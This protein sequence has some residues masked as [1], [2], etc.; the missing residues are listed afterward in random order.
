VPKELDEGEGID[1]RLDQ[2][3]GPAVEGL[4]EERQA[5]VIELKRLHTFIAIFFIKIATGETVCVQIDS[6]ERHVNL[7]R[8]KVRKEKHRSHLY[9][10]VNLLSNPHEVDA[11]AGCY[12]LERDLFVPGRQT[13][14]NPSFQGLYCTSNRI[15]IIIPSLGAIRIAIFWALQRARASGRRAHTLI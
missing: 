15:G 7:L 9:G 12:S 10:V 13:A 2:N 6:K 11:I 14:S 1:G 5:V 4:L 3:M 8:E